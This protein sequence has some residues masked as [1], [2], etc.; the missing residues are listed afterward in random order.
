MCLSS[1]STLQIGSLIE[2]SLYSRIKR[3]RSSGFSTLQI[4]SLI[5]AI[6]ALPDD[7]VVASFST[8]QIGSLIEAPVHLPCA[9][10]E[11]EVSVPFKSGR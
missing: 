11:I 10:A 2:A 4:G 8:L 3:K 1:F 7:A 6:D 5:E 9:V